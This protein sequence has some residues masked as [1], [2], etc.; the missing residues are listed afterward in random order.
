MLNEIAL[1]EEI[2]TS[3][4]AV[5][6][7]RSMK[8][9]ICQQCLR[10]LSSCICQWIAPCQNQ[11]EVIVLQHPLEVANAKGSARL[12]HLSL[13][14]SQLFIGEQF[15]QQHWSQLLTAPSEF[16][17]LPM[18]TVLLY[19]DT[20][21]NAA[22]DLQLAP[23]PAFVLEASGIQPS[24]IRLI[25]LD[26]TWRKSRKMLYRNPVLQGLPRFSLS[27]MPASHYRIRKAHK[28]DQLST[29]EATVYAL[30][31]LEKTENTYHKLLNAF[32]GFVEQ[33]LARIPI[34]SNASA[35]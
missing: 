20:A 15:D 33:Q 4:N 18:Q 34:T 9:A 35:D 11:T 17:G 1:A 24:Q 29:L 5:M 28:A 2:P 25:V 6:K 21:D 8:R 16:T 14:R 10:P 23:P 26:A 19:P 32:D 31:R 27:D 30:M 3:H 12:L 13:Q 22:D 7:V